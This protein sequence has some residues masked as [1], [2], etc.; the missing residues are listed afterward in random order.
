[1][2]AILK[3]NGAENSQ[4]E[5]GL[6]FAVTE[7]VRLLDT[8]FKTYIVNF[9]YADKTHSVIAH[10]IKNVSDARRERNPIY[11]N[12]SPGL[13][14][15]S[16]PISKKYERVDPNTIFIVNHINGEYAKHSL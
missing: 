4:R 12:S 15:S 14:F 3:R 8:K 13:L 10:I 6:A 11:L 5:K 2:W 16:E 1:M 7:L 9:V